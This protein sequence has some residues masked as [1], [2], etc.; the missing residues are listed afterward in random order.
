MAA[1]TPPKRTFEVVR[2]PED[3]LVRIKTAETGRVT[4]ALSVEE[5]SQMRAALK[6]A[7][8]SGAKKGS[9]KARKNK[10]S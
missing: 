8:Q 9:K 5:A 10:S 1:T 4:L 3:G 2:S 7:L 6:G